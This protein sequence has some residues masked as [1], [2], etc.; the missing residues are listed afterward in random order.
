MANPE[1]QIVEAIEN[2]TPFIASVRDEFPVDG[3]KGGHLV[4]VTGFTQDGGQLAEIR[5]NDPS[6]W[7]RAHPVLPAPRFLASFSGRVVLPSGA[8]AAPE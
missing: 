7:G 6:A 2:G 3:S 1:D 8:A 5:F 4:V